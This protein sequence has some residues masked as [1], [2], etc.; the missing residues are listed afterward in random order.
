MTLREGSLSA[1]VARLQ[2]VTSTRHSN[3]KVFTTN[4]G[5]NIIGWGENHQ[6]NPLSIC[7]DCFGRRMLELTYIFLNN[8]QLV[9]ISFSLFLGKS[10][11]VLDCVLGVSEQLSANQKQNDRNVTLGNHL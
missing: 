11:D 2:Q 1:L 5:Q 9:L 6:W 10:A 4:Q 8:R 3:Y 7:Q